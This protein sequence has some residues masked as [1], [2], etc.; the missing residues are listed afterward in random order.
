MKDPL[1]IEVIAPTM[2]INTQ[3]G[4]LFK[5]D[6][7]ENFLEPN[8][9]LSELAFESDVKYIIEN[10]WATFYNKIFGMILTTKGTPLVMLTALMLG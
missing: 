2:K 6:L 5:K 9:F 4:S 8:K 3:V 1:Q 10:D 7:Y